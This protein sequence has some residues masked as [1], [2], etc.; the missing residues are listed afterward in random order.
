M[1]QIKKKTYRSKKV[2]ARWKGLG[3]KW[4]MAELKALAHLV[5]ECVTNRKLTGKTESGA[6]LKNNW[7]LTITGS[8]MLHQTFMFSVYFYCQQTA[9]FFLQTI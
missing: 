1:F 7:Y 4:L 9:I 8:N 2:L 6:D 5:A 3:S